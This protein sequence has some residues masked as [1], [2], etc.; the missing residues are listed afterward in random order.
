[1]PTC[2][3][4]DN[5][6]R[7]LTATKWTL[8]SAHFAVVST[9]MSCYHCRILF[10]TR[11]LLKINRLSSTLPTRMMFFIA[12]RWISAVILPCNYSS[13]IAHFLGT[14]T[15]VIMSSIV[16]R[17]PTVGASFFSSVALIRICRWTATAWRYQ[18]PRFRLVYGCVVCLVYVQVRA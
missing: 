15:A 13:L 7:L 6:R 12:S 4:R 2:D 3:S 9:V 5:V 11:F 16:C 14:F 10:T 18:L 1:M 17:A 8:S